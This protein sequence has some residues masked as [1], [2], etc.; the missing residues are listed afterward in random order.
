MKPFLRRLAG[1]KDSRGERRRG[2]YCVHLYVI[3]YGRCFI[4]N[5]RLGRI[6][7]DGISNARR[8]DARAVLGVGSADG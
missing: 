2:F 4:N 7:F 3:G 6:F 5:L 1:V 8:F